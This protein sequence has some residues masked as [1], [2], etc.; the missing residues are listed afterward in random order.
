MSV[1]KCGDSFWAFI[2]VSNLTHA[3]RVLEKHRELDGENRLVKVVKKLE[4]RYQE[5]INTALYAP[6]TLDIDAVVKRFLDIQSDLDYHAYGAL[7]TCLF[8]LQFDEDRKVVHDKLP[9]RP[10]GDK[11]TAWFNF[12]FHQTFKITRRREL[13]RR[14]VYPLNT[15]IL[16]LHPDRLTGAFKAAWLEGNPYDP[17]LVKTFKTPPDISTTMLC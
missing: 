10:A 5:I 4:N 6:Q 2:P 8:L 14:T 9:E 3:L 7:K 16:E 11:T 15:S 12:N 1:G 13:D 17:I